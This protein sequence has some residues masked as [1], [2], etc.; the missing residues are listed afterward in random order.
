MS[1]VDRLTAD[2]LDESGPGSPRAWR[3]IMWST[4]VVALLASIAYLGMKPDEW[5]VYQ[6]DYGCTARANIDR[7]Y[8]KSRC[9]GTDGVNRDQL[10]ANGSRAQPSRYG[11]PLGL[12]Q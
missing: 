4:V 5:D 7:S 12:G 1:S 9:A 8:T 3:A 11:E 6:K 10:S 2:E